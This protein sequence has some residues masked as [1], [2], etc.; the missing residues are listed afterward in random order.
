MTTSFRGPRRLSACP[1]LAV[2][3]II[4]LG[5]RGRADVVTLTD[6][7]TFNGQ[8][9]EE[10]AATVRIDTKV[11]GTRVILG[12]PRVDVRSV[13]AKPIPARFFERAPAEARVSDPRRVKDPGSLDA[14][15]A[16]VDEARRS[17]AS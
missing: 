14:Q 16:R 6:G 1:S 2:A 15:L 12:F 4:L 5:I 10:S 9:L 8:V 13:E 7:R 11:E 3:A 17:A